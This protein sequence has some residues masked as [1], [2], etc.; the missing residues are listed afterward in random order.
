MRREKTENKTDMKKTIKKKDT[1]TRTM[2]GMKVGGEKEDDREG[3]KSEGAGK[4]DWGQLADRA[5]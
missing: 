4:T 1:T 2:M 3:E 5:V